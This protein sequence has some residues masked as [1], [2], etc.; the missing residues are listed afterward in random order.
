[1]YRVTLSPGHKEIII[2]TLSV[3]GTEKSDTFGRH[4]LAMNM[5]YFTMEE[6]KKR[7]YFNVL[8]KGS[9][10]KINRKFVIELD[11]GSVKDQNN[12]NKVFL[13]GKL[14]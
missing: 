3:F 11:K 12:F 13:M 6:R 2:T 5:E 4:Q 7:L 14:E 1:M 10:N 8:E 9:I